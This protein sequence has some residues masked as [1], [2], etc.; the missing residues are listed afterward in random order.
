[1]QTFCTCWGFNKAIWMLWG[2][3]QQHYVG[4]TGL[5]WTFFNLHPLLVGYD[6][7]HTINARWWVDPNRVPEAL[8]SS[9]LDLVWILSYIFIVQMNVLWFIKWS[10]MSPTIDSTTWVHLRLGTK[11]G[12]HNITR[13]RDLAPFPNGEAKLHRFCLI[14][15]ICSICYQA[16]RTL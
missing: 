4:C 7:K 11:W 1:M 9:F 6:M 8:S 5:K 12:T 16:T 10:Y 13:P 15:K 3:G 14:C 2:L